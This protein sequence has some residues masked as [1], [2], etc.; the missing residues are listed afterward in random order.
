[1][2]LCRIGTKAAKELYLYHCQKRSMVPFVQ[3]VYQSNDFQ[4]QGANMQKLDVC[5]DLHIHDHLNKMNWQMA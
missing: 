3:Q 1:M 2:V 4:A 5:F